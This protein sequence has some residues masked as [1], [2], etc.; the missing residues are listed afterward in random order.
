MY[1][2]ANLRIIS[3]DITKFILCSS[4]V[5]TDAVNTSKVDDDLR[6]K[7]CLDDENLLKLSEIGLFL[8]ESYGTPR[9]IEW[10]IFDV[11]QLKLI[12]ISQFQRHSIAE[13]N[14]FASISPNDIDE[15]F[16]TMGTNS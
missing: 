14:L 6:K 16:H 10:A 3:N 12:F 2:L 11:S 7:L 9:D 1:R 5:P 13:Q 15:F 8:Q 4:N